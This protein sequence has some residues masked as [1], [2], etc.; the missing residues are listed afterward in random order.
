MNIEKSMSENV[1][2]SIAV[3]GESSHQLAVIKLSGKVIENSF[4][5]NIAE[6]EER[7]QFDNNGIPPK[8]YT[9]IE[10]MFQEIRCQEMLERVEEEPNV[11]TEHETKCILDNRDNDED[12]SDEHDDEINDYNV[13]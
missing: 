6:L 3:S 7:G 1:S 9:E 10:D 12:I 8:V 5:V 4:Q 11:I 2:T 13:C